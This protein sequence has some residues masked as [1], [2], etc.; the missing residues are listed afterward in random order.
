MNAP[1]MVKCIAGLV[2]IREAEVEKLTAS[3][4]RQESVRA[5]F[6]RN[7]HAMQTLFDAAGGAPA[8]AVPPTLL[9]NQ[10]GY[11]LAMLDMMQAHR[12]ALRAHEEHMQ[13]ERQ[14]L[15]ATAARCEMWRREL[16]KRERRLDAA[17]ERGEQRSQDELAAQ[18]W[19]RS[20]A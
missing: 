11:R 13:V 19:I 1:R 3:L 2:S 14:L 5:R 6:H 17:R 9:H 7:L 18:A 10:A 16:R 8:Q 4:A 15:A 12:T 20:R